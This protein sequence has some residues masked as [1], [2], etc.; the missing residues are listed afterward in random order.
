MLSNNV[1]IITNIE[2]YENYVNNKYGKNYLQQFKE[3]NPDV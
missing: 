1:E 2:P 3:V